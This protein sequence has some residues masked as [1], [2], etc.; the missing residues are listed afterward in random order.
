MLNENNTIYQE[1]EALGKDFGR[2]ETHKEVADYLKDYYFIKDDA[3]DKTIKKIHKKFIR[4][5][6]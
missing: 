5:P 3:N 1:F 6:P 4:I 2:F